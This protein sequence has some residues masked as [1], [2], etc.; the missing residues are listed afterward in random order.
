M[1]KVKKSKSQLLV[2]FKKSNQERRKKLAIRNGYKSSS[3]YYDYLTNNKT[4][5]KTK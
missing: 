5:S 1:E 4:K 2:E 3:A